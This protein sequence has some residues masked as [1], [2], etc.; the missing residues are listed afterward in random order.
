MIFLR[1]IFK[2]DKRLLMFLSKTIC[3]PL[4][5][6]SHFHGVAILDFSRAEKFSRTLMTLFQFTVA[7]ASIRA[8]QAEKLVSKL[9][10][11]KAGVP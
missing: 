10:R 4:A 3:F 8:P 2:F 1:M 7:L 9:L 5:R 11:Y 6:H